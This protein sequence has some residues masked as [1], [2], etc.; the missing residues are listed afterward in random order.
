[1]KELVQT[2]K[3]SKRIKYQLYFYSTS[4]KVATLYKEIPINQETTPVGQM[5]MKTKVIMQ[6]KLNR[7]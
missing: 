2:T 4:S 1:M 7:R 5:I 3:N 6:Q